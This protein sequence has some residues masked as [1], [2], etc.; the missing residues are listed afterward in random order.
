MP[1]GRRRCRG[2]PDAAEAAAR[3][4]VGDSYA[5]FAENLFRQMFFKPCKVERRP[6]RGA[7]PADGDP[8]HH[9]Q[10]AH[11][12]AR[13]DEARADEAWGDESFP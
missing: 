9:A 13:A 1:S 6:R 10:H 8:E 3:K 12:E 11:H 2:D 4:I 7:L 5:A